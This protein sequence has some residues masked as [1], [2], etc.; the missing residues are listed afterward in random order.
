[1]PFVMILFLPLF[2]YVLSTGVQRRK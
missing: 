2:F 1:V